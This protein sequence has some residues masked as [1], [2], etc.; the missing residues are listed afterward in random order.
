M[1]KEKTFQFVLTESECKLFRLL[2]DVETDFQTEYPLIYHDTHPKLFTPVS[3][4]HRP[5]C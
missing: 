2:R 1:A 4:V 5:R 3:L